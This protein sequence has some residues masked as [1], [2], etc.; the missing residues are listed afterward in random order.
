MFDFI[1]QEPNINTALFC[2]ISYIVLLSILYKKLIKRQY[3]K[4]GEQQ[5]SLL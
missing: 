1:I 3:S 2:L 5:Y 4:L